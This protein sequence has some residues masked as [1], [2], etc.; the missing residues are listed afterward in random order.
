MVIFILIQSAPQSGNRSG[1]E[2]PIVTVKAERT[3][4]SFD[5]TASKQS[6]FVVALNGM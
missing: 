1:C 2:S 5:V 3:V 6:L 4:K